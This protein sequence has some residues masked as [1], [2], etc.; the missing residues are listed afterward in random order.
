MTPRLTDDELQELREEIERELVRARRSMN[1]SQATSG[2]VALDQTAVGRLSRMDAM[3]SQA[4]Q[5]ELLSREASRVGEL[6]AALRRLAEGR[7]GRCDACGGPI[8]YGRLL[9][10]PEA[11]HCAGCR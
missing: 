4:M 1:I 7:Y 10:V 8:P 11:R 5:K 9:V 6:E 2:P 3:Q